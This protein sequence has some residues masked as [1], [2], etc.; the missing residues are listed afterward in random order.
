MNSQ[1]CVNCNNKKAINRT[2]NRLVTESCGHVKCMDCLLKEKSGCVACAEDYSKQ[3][4]SSVLEVIE[5]VD[6]GNAIQKEEQTA[7]ED[8]SGKKPE[9]T[10]IRIET[11]KDTSIV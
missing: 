8:L 11:G 6:D 10:H 5:L 2:D 7:S 3:D 4:H 9:T 1:I